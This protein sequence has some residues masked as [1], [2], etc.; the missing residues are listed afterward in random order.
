MVTDSATPNWYLKI[1]PPIWTLGML[2]AAYGMQRS[3]EWAAAVY[4]RSLPLAIALAAAGIGLVP[5]FL[6]A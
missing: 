3:F 5:A 4:V 6:K 1:P 2:V